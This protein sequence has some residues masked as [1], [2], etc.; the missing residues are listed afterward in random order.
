MLGIALYS[1]H[2]AK[3][4]LAASVVVL[5]TGF[6]VYEPTILPG[7]A[8]IGTLVL[9]RLAGASTNLSVSDALLFFGTLSALIVFRPGGDREVKA[10][11]WLVVAYEVMMILPVIDNPYRADFVEWGH[12]AFLAGGALIC[13]WVVGQRGHARFG[14]GAFL[15]GACVLSLWA[16]LESPLHH[17]HPV[18]LP[19]GYQKNPIG[20]LVAFGTLVAYANPGYLDLSTRVRHWVIAITV[21]GIA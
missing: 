18:F 10:L 4:A 5:F 13:G 9:E 21:V 20:D 16:G 14:L 6:A 15:F 17:F 2:D 8:I 12:E 3:Y 7:L 11:L 19:G 1:T